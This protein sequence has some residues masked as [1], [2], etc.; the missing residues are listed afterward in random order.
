MN[1]QII[2]IEEKVVSCRLEDGHILDIARQWFPAQINID[3]ELDFNV[4]AVLQKNS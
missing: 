3:D 1:I 2:R 4:E